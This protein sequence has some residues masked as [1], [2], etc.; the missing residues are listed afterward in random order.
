MVRKANCRWSMCADYTDLNKACPKDSYPLPSIDSLGKK[1]ICRSDI[2]ET[3]ITDNRTQITSE[4]VADFCETCK[5]QQI[6]A[7]VEQGQAE[8][9]NKILL[10]G[11][12]K[13]LD[14]AKGNMG[15]RAPFCT[16]VLSHY[17]TVGNRG[18]PIQAYIRRRCHD[19]SGNTRGHPAEIV[20]REDSKRRA[21][22]N[23]SRSPS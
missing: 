21:N 9:G 7:S 2:P 8:A 23:Q 19:P 11:L 18:N 5:I 14:D 1:L 4:V 16:L 13:R 15:R 17:R 12:K 3:I 22:T 10:N 6:F 20:D